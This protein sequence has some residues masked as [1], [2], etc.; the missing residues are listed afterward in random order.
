MGASMTSKR[1][2]LQA[3]RNVLW[4]ECLHLMTSVSKVWRKHQAITLSS[5]GQG[6][7]WTRTTLLKLMETVPW[8]NKHNQPQR[9]DNPADQGCSVPASSLVLFWVNGAHGRTA[10][11]RTHLHRHTRVQDSGDPHRPFPLPL[12]IILAISEE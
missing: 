4:K 7:C 5:P 8:I 6:H 12:L 2:H 11:A 3:F 10:Y 9:A 1:G